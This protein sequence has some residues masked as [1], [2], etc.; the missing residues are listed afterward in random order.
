MV[1][2]PEL[3]RGGYVLAVPCTTA[4]L[5]ARAAL[6]NC[7]PIEAGE[8]GIPKR[9]VAQAELCSSVRVEDLDGE[10]VG[11]VSAAKWRDLVRAVGYV[12]NASCEPE[13]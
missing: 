6:R 3:S 13:P 11:V 8:S 5:E 10:R 1:S 2:R 7:V 4:R 12:P 9:C